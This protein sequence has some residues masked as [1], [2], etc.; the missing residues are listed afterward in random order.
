MSRISRYQESIDKF[1]KNKN[2]NTYFA[3]EFNVT[4]Y[5]KLIESD[6][7]GGIIVS[8]LFNHNA[9]KSNI[10]GHGYFIGIM[11]DIILTIINSKNKNTNINYNLFIG[12][13]KI[14]TENLNIIKHNKSEEL[15][16]IILTALTYYNDNI[17]DI[18]VDYKIGEIQKMT[19]SDLLN[20]NKITEKMY[21][22]ISQINKYKQDDFINYITKIYGKLGKIIFV[23]SW[24]LG[25]GKLE[26][27][28]QIEKIGEKFGLIYKICYDF[29]NIIKDIDNINIDDNTNNTNNISNNIL[30]NIGIQESF[31]LFMETKSIFYEESF[32]LEIY[33]HT[34]KEVID[35]LETKIDKTLEDCKIDLKSVYSSFSEKT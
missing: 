16:K 5:K 35:E 24:I 33:T 26:N 15:N 19:K 25:G 34:M 14:L 29:E 10:K 8:T 30:I 7:L 21:K 20:L 23:L 17:Y 28:Y 3:E 27:I 12:L 11:I 31:A 4:I 32:K 13:Y 2:I 1:I 18:L 22:K 6:H 9:K